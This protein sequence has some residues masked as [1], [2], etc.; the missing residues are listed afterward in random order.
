MTAEKQKLIAELRRE[1]EHIGLT[2]AEA[3]SV[4]ARQI[5]ASTLDHPGETP[6]QHVVPVSGGW[7]VMRDL[8]N[9]DLGLFEKKDQAIAA[10]REIATASGARGVV[11]DDLQS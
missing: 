10:A 11:H 6:L 8:P 5:L 4:A 7:L 9:L 2:G 1:L 3:E